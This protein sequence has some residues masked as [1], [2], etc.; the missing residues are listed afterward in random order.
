MTLDRKPLIAL[1]AGGSAALLLGALGF[2]YIGGLAPCHL[3]LLQRW[4]HLAAV[5]IGALALVVAGTAIQR[6]LALAG[7]GAAA[8][9]SGLGF[10][11]AGVEQG[12]WQGPTSCTSSGQAGLS[13]DQL[14]DQIMSAPLVQCDKI[15]WEFMGI[16]MAGWNFAIS[17]GLVIIWIMAAR[18]KR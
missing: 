18:A 7:A 17:L 5:V 3:C 8:V 10:Y 6:G 12:W 4:P 2:Q 9:T 11:H 15:A 16:S 13:A 1:A 14:F